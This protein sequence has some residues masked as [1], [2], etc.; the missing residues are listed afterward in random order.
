MK[1]IKIIFGILLCLALPGTL[2]SFFTGTINEEA[3]EV[4]GHLIAIAI[5]VFLIYLCFKPSKKKDNSL[6]QNK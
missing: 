1:A 3:P 5:I 6:V 2:Y 4:I